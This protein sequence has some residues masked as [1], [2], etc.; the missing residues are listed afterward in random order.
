MQVRPKKY[1]NWGPVTC[2]ETGKTYPNPNEAARAI[3]YKTGEM[4]RMSVMWGKAC[5]GLHFSDGRLAGEELEKARQKL[6]MEARQNLRRSILK[7][8]L[9]TCMPVPARGII[10]NV[11]IDALH[12]L[13]VRTR[14]GLVYYLRTDEV[15]LS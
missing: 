13:T 11:D 14:D 10:T 3:G 7:P 15:K 4:V 8:G 2:L 1:R 9:I 6:E 5:K 12:P